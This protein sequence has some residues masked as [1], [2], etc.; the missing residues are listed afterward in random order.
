MRFQ[1][2][3][4]AF[5]LLLMAYGLH[6]PTS[7]MGQSYR[8]PHPD[9]IKVLLTNVAIQIECTAGVN[10]LYNFKFERAESQF[11]WLKRNYPEHP[12]PY[13]VLGLIEWWKIVPNGAVTR[14]DEQFFSY[15]DSSIYF[16]EQ[17]Y[18]Q[19]EDNPE[20]PFFLAAAY[21]FKGRLHAERE[22][23]TRAA[24]DG[25]RSLKYL[26][27]SKE[28]ADLSPELLFGDGL[29]NYYSVWIPENYPML[30]PLLLFFRKGDKELGIEQLETVMKEAF[31]AKVEAMYFL[32]RI[33]AAEE[34]RPFKAARLAEYLHT[35]FPDNPYF[36]RYYARILY[37]LGRHAE[38]IQ[39]CETILDRIEQGMT[40]Y[41]AV[42][43]RYAAFFLG[44]Y[45]ATTGR[46]EEL[47]ME[48]F[49]K[50]VNFAEQIEALESG[51]YHYSLGGIARILA[52]REQ[53]EQAMAYY[54]K[55]LDHADRKS[56]VYQQAKDF[57]K[58]FRKYRRQQRREDRG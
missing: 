46:N 12:L 2:F 51:Y 27:I 15:M 57:R 7:V 36:H 37:T 39:T 22:S 49:K 31:Y 18:E 10:D 28:H 8:L 11:Q 40:G 44:N 32:M 19:D 38:M 55:V 25:K 5:L 52:E 48:Y 6:T 24:I 4:R 34:E 53:M 43:G 26:E 1:H 23:W 16:A 50:A 20:A 42:S 17:L 13:F 45:Y 29:Y 14:Y 41:E 35:T 30:K 54:E 47:A 33:Y 58:T 56:S 21:A 3:L 9:S